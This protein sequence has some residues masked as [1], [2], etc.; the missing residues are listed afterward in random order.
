MVW[1]PATSRFAINRMQKKSVCFL[2][3]SLLSWGISHLIV[4]S[5][6]PRHFN[7][8]A[9]LNQIRSFSLTQP[10][11][12]YLTSLPFS[13]ISKYTVFCFFM[14]L[15]ASILLSIFLLHLFKGNYFVFLNRSILVKCILF[16]IW[17]YLSFALSVEDRFLSC[18]CLSPTL[19]RYFTPFQPLLFLLRAICQ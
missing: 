7:K 9:A 11:C 1:S 10:F 3:L 5:S 19:W 15:F 8:H 14:D 12:C 17:K 16:S 4:F 6:C 2:L 18:H 13:D